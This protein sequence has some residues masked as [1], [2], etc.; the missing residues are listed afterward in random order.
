MALGLAFIL[1]LLFLAARLL[2]GM[3]GG[4]SFGGGPLKVVGGLAVG[5]RERVVLVEIGDSWLVIGIAPGQIQ[6]L[7]TM[8]KGEAPASVAEAKP[9]G[10]WLKQFVE[11]KNE[12]I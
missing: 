3:N 4:R 5:A 12:L 1:G 10:Q 7:H 2:R 6:T 11:H 8:P 9:F